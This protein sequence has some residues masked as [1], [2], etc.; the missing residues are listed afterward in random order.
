MATPQSNGQIVQN[1]RKRKKDAQF[2]SRRKRSRILN[3]PTAE[4]LN[5]LQEAETTFHSNLF[6]M[7]V[8]ELIKELNEKMSIREELESWIEELK[9][10]ITNIPESS[11]CA[12]KDFSLDGI[13][14]PIIQN[15]ASEKGTFKFCPPSNITEIGSY[16]LQTM[17]SATPVVDIAIEIPKE[18]WQNRDFLN[19]QYHRKRAFYLAYI[20]RCLR[21]SDLIEDMNFYYQNECYLKPTLLIIPK[22][23]EKVKVSLTAYPSVE[24]SF[25]YS[26]FI[27]SRNNIRPSWFFKESEDT[28]QSTPYYNAS[29]LSDLLTI[30]L[31]EFLEE[32]ICSESIKTGTILLKLWCFQRGL[33]TGYGRLNGFL[34][35]MFVAYLLKKRKITPLMSAYQVFRCALLSF[36]N[37]KILEEGI[38]LCDKDNEYPTL[39]NFKFHYD[40]VFADISGDLNL[41]YSVTKET[42]SR[43]QHEAKLGL[44]ILDSESPD[45]FTFLFTNKI[46]FNE[47]FEYVLQLKGE[48]KFKKY[49][50]KLEL[51]EELLDFGEN[52]SACVLRK[53]Y[54]ILKQGLNKRVSLVDVTKAPLSP[55]PI[56]EA[57][58]NP[59]VGQAK[60]FRKFWGDQ[61]ELRRFQDGTIREAVYWPAHTAAER[62]KVFSKMVVDI[63]ARH[64]NADPLQT[65]VHG[66]EVDCILEVPEDMLI[67]LPP[68]GTG[69][70][71][72][73]AIM[74]SFNTLSKQL[75][76]LDKL[77]LQVA[78]IQGSSPSFRFSEVF[79][80]LSVLHQANAKHSYVEGHIMKLKDTGSGVPPYTPALK[81]I[82]NLE[83]SGKWPDDV[84]AIKRVKAAFYLKIAHL[85]KSKLS[86]IAMAFPT[87][88]DI[89]KDGFVFRIELACHK[90]IFLMQQIQLPD[91]G[92]KIQENRESRN[93]EIKTEIVPKINS[94]LHGLHQQHNS[95]GTACRLAKRWISAQLKQSFIEDITVDLIVAKVYLHPEP[96]SC[97]SSPQVALI[98]FLTLLE[99]HDWAMFPLV[100]N[101][102]NEL[103]RPE[104][105][106]IYSNFN[107]QRSTLPPMVIV[108]PFDKRGCMWTK[109]KPVP[110]IL[111]RLTILA[112]AS[113][114]S[115]N[116]V[117]YNMKLPD[118][119]EIFRPPLDSFDILIY[120]KRNE[121][122]RLGCAVDVYMTDTLPSFK[123]YKSEM[124]EVYPIV[125]YDPVQKYVE[126]LRE[127]FG[128]FAF[129]LYDIYGG[130]FVAVV[131]KKNAFTPKDFTASHANCRKPY[132][133]SNRVIPDVERIMEDF[134]LLGEGLVKKIVKQT[135][136]WQIP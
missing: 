60:E 51:K 71:A 27:P 14:I 112:K 83:G 77:P 8:D 89:F 22:D 128:E 134:E 48:K 11:A 106:E 10:F 20:A 43:I 95:F 67:S 90:E 82:V 57:P 42:I 126:E 56:T 91:G 54:E 129:F 30:R 81:V 63:L 118:A 120:L 25:K 17:C 33:I 116:F 92:I 34:L 99:T 46:T 127:N 74:Q 38:T 119:K 12:I 59:D 105:E 102:N 35:T 62:R 85:V 39:E 72:H 13:A 115:L 45:N 58:P 73:A 50:K 26:R 114:K 3:V 2:S 103:Q 117:L 80:P 98:R 122:P 28:E 76:N 15:P 70:E 84:E 55:W 40:V 24:A 136:N 108:N 109:N 69:E 110:L 44:L 107:S 132:G 97:P 135:E 123:P 75:R 87:H 21:E 125:D 79:P 113:L 64:I 16:V 101:L 88:V 19:Y 41:C 66:T 32:S 23:I 36:Q 7:Q 29:I 124:N 100:V 94:I 61:S 53:V 6:K 47:K 96:Y 52:T 31:N 121:M 93:L 131:W 5:E 9:D 65:V 111:K 130:D 4:E 49:A 86:L 18:C 104:L 78:S 1:K 68:Y 37:E 133:D